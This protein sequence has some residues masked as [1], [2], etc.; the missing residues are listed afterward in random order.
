MVFHTPHF[1]LTGLNPSMAQYWYVKIY[2]NWGMALI[3][4][5]IVPG[6]VSRK[7]GIKKKDLGLQWGNKKLGLILLAVGLAI[8]PLIGL[9]VLN[10]PQM[11]AEYPL[12]HPFANWQSFDLLGFNPGLW[13]LGEISYVVIYYIPY[14]F[15][16]RGFAQFPLRKYGKIN[17]FWIILWTTC[18]T[19]IIHLDVPQS[20][21]AGAILVGIIYG[22]LALNTNSIYYGLIHHAS[23]GITTDIVSTGLIN[24][25]F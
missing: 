16:W 21:L 22:W 2:Y 11:Q 9:E 17:N 13:I 19:S 14:E 24:G 12:L 23:T 25:L 4:F 20:E 7:L 5:L 10:D 1:V 3:L 18:L 6:L 15:F 8:L